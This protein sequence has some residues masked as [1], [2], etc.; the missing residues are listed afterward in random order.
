MQQDNR[1][2]TGVAGLTIKDLAAVDASPFDSGS[3]ASLLEILRVP[4]ELLIV[5]VPIG[6][7]ISQCR[8]EQARRKVPNIERVSEYLLRMSLLLSCRSARPCSPELNE[9]WVK[10]LIW[11]EDGRT[12][13][14]AEHEPVRQQANRSCCIW[15]KNLRRLEILKAEFHE[16]YLE[17]NMRTL[18]RT[19]EG[20]ISSTL[21]RLLTAKLACLPLDYHPSRLWRRNHGSRSSL[22]SGGSEDK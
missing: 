10:R 8:A 15:S 18:S 13:S 11:N 4:C 5:C 12:C 19:S 17:R 7:A 21:S 14:V 2:R 20:C 16:D 9:P 6:T 22:A 3:G 1:G